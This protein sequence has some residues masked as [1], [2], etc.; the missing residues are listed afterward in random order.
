MT[1]KVK[2]YVSICDTIESIG[3]LESEWS[4]LHVHCSRSTIFNSFDFLYLAVQEFATAGETLLFITVRH[5]A[6]NRLVA[7]FPFKICPFEWRGLDFK[8]ITYAGLDVTD[9]VYPVIENGEEPEAWH[10]AFSHIKSIREVWHF[11]DLF[12][13]ERGLYAALAVRRAFLPGRYIRRQSPDIQS[14]IVDLACDWQSF[15]GRHPKMRKRIKRMKRQFG[16]GFEFKC[17]CD[18]AAYESCL[19]QYLMLESRSWRKKTA[20]G[21]S[22][23]KQNIS[24][25]RRLFETLAEKSQ[26]FFGFLYIEGQLVAAEI[27]YTHDNTVY[28]TH[29]CYDESFKKYSP[30]MVSVSLFLK[31]FFNG[32]YKD[33]DFLGGFAHYINPWASHIVLS[34]RITVARVTPKVL[35]GFVF[36]V[37]AK[38]KLQNLPS[39][40]KK[41]FLTE[42][43]L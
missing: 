16:A 42:N 20:V 12:E 18:P 21:I 24:F 8:L 6:D 26:L 31:N 34:D 41:K 4:A 27:A 19:N 5:P 29:G 3:R 38:L 22:Q 14:P 11:I 2:L 35:L 9:K 1:S 37:R 17:I 15:S 25:H 43:I 36:A 7:V 32:Q 28:F 10:A 13:V 40:F 39:F 23:S 33:G 30:G